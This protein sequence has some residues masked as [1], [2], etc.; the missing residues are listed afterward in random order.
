MTEDDPPPEEQEEKPGCGFD[1]ACHWFV[2]LGDAIFNNRPEGLARAGLAVGAG[3]ALSF[4]GLAAS[5]PVVEGAFVA[6]GQTINVTGQGI[7]HIVRLHTLGRAPQGKSVFSFGTSADDIVTLVRNAEA[8]TPVAQ[9]GQYAGN[10]ARI[11]DAG[12]MIGV[13]RT[14]GQATR[15]YTVITDRLGNLVTVFPGLP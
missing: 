5:G 9:T 12:R 6:G 3:A 2:G 10:Y 11:V 13:D 15:I 8:V 14:T 7:T 1:L 4:V